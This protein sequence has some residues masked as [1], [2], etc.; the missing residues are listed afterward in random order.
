M[1]NSSRFLIAVMALSLFGSVAQVKA[2]SGAG[3]DDKIAAS[4]KVQAALDERCKMQC[5]TLSANWVHETSR[6][7]RTDIAASPR[8]KQQLDERT[9]RRVVQTETAT[10]RSSGSDGI[11][12]SPKVRAMLDERRQIVEIAPLK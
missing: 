10:L 4:P 1:K 7:S 12:A 5:A 9:P 8:L 6:S 3:C 11:A 2:G